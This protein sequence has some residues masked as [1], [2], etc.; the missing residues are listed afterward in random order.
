MSIRRS[1]SLFVSIVIALQT[2][3][4]QAAEARAE[5]KGPVLHTIT[6]TAEGYN[7]RIMPM[8]RERSAMADE[9]D[10]L[11]N[12]R[13]VVQTRVE[14]VYQ[15]NEELVS[16]SHAGT[17]FSIAPQMLKDYAAPPQTAQPKPTE[18][19]MAV[20]VP[21]PSAED[22]ET[23]QPGET[24]AAEGASSAAPFPEITPVPLRDGYARTL[25]RV[26][27]YASL[28]GEEP[29]GTL[30][31]AAV[32]Y[33]AS[34]SETRAQIAF[35][36]ES[37]LV[38]GFANC[39]SLVN[40]N[41]SE[42][43]QVRQHAQAQPDICTYQGNPLP[44][45]GEY[46][47]N[48]PPAEQPDAATEPVATQTPEAIGGGAEPAPTPEADNTPDAQPTELPIP[49]TS[50]EPTDEPAVFPTIEPTA[51]AAQAPADTPRPESTQIPKEESTAEPSIPATPE[52]TQVPKEELTLEPQNPSTPEPT[53][54]AA[55]E[56]T[57]GPMEE[58]T[59][60]P[61]ETFV[62]QPEPSEAAPAV[63]AQAL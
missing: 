2:P 34:V 14:S 17:G 57:A 27:V 9:G 22:G 48:V 56:P 37:G 1:V 19:P 4:G 36:T 3:I 21:S 60:E 24:L 26:A 40:L 62:P 63:T 59:E 12:A 5:E 10:H 55:A 16:V 7:G 11:R 42:A 39:K 33:V 41:E 46:A 38:E 49:E 54:E 45:I 13:G 61:E 52:P 25:E 15:A 23:P 50:A 58:P 6:L 43:Q 30:P 32:V 51:A 20:P 29:Q 44:R 18:T 31:A 28:Q 53:Q 35:D 8:E 47:P